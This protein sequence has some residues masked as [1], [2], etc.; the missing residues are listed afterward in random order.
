MFACSAAETMRPGVSSMPCLK[1]GPV[2]AASFCSST[3][4]A[5]NFLKLSMGSGTTTKAVSIGRGMHARV[6]VAETC[7]ALPWGFWD[8]VHAGLLHRLQERR[9]QRATLHHQA[10]HPARLGQDRDRVAHRRCDALEFPFPSPRQQ[11]RDTRLSALTAA[12]TSALSP[13]ELPRNAATLTSARRNRA[14]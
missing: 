9:H 12:V 13:K 3:S 14:N 1:E 7:Q 5:K 10:R 11:R 6:V 4:C 2:C 8:Q